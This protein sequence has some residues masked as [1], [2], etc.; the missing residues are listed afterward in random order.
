MGR[1]VKFLRDGLDPSKGRIAH[2]LEPLPAD[3]AQ[4]LC[5]DRLVPRIPIEEVWTVA[6]DVGVVPL[7][8]SCKAAIRKEW[9]KEK[10]PIPGYDKNGR[11]LDACECGSKFLD[12]EDYRDHLPCPAIGW[13][14]KKK[15]P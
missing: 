7:C 1:W 9:E 8:E 2:Y 11:P 13:A 4:V 14:R 5:S 15:K 3:Q 6:R 10:Q 12:A